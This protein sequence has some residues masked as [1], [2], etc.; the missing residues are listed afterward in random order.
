MYID[1]LDSFPRNETEFHQV[2]D[3]ITAAV[4]LHNSFLSSFR[5]ASEVC[6]LERE[7]GL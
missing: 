3:R 5:N 4:N 7:K 2:I 6:S 1:L